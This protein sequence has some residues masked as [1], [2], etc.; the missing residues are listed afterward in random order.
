MKFGNP[1]FEQ[2]EKISLLQRWLIVHSIIYYELGDNIVPDSMWDKN[3]RQLA[4]KMEKY[5]K[6]LKK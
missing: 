4:K 2:Y 6:S 3:A 5:P 1:Y